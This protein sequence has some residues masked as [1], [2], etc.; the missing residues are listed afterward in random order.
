MPRLPTQKIYAF[1]YSCSPFDRPVYKTHSQNAESPLNKKQ[2]AETIVLRRII[3]GVSGGDIDL[4]APQ[5]HI[6]YTTYYRNK[7]LCKHA[8]RCQ[9]FV[10]FFSDIA[11][12]RISDFLVKC[13]YGHSVS[14]RR[15]Q[16]HAPV[17]VSNGTHASFLQENIPSLRLHIFQRSPVTSKLRAIRMPSESA[18]RRLPKTPESASE[19]ECLKRSR[20]QAP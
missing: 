15:R 13:G 17:A 7:Q 5:F 8:R 3:S 10:E 14:P 18:V 19:P 2:T 20:S 4:K 12:E 9:D 11:H 16:S 6:K 1:S